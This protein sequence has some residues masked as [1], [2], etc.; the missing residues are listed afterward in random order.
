MPSLIARRGRNAG[1][2]T[3]LQSKPQIERLRKAFE[4]MK[5]RIHHALSSS[6]QTSFDVR[7]EYRTS[8]RLFMDLNPSTAPLCGSHQPFWVLST[9]CVNEFMRW[10]FNRWIFAIDFARVRGTRRDYSWEDHQRNM[11]MVTILLRSLKASVNC[12]HIAK[13]SQIFKGH[14][15][16]RQGKSLQGMNF[17]ESIRST[18]LACL[19]RELFNWLDL[20]LH[21][22]LVTSTT[23]SFN[24]L[25]GIFSNW[26]NVAMASESYCKA[27]KL[28]IQLRDCSSDDCA[29]ILHS[30]RRM[31][32]QQFALQVIQQLCVNTDLSEGEN[33]I[34]GGSHGLSFDIFCALVGEA[35]HLTRPRNG[36][37]GLGNTY[38][39]MV[40]L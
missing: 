29:K 17:E 38:P 26:R 36:M 25:Q 35:P 4:A 2:V 39:T 23:F 6:I 37:H 28:E 33:V 20:H 9:A 13:Q 16:D 34:Q 30:M 1:V 15:K 8:W 21:D 18:G 24:E 11:V 3:S 31:V 22:E 12:H 19:P 40:R 7:E 10:E 27:R 32:Y 14:Y 5:H